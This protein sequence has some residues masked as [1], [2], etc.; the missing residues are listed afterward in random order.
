MYSRLQSGFV[1]GALVSVFIAAI[2]LAMFVV[3]GP[4]DVH[5]HL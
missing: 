3:A 5:G 1:G 4:P 2:M